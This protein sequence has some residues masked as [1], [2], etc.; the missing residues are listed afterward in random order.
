MEMMTITCDI[1]YDALVS[2]EYLQSVNPPPPFNFLFVLF[3]ICFCFVFCF[4]LG[5]VRYPC[6]S[7]TAS[8]MSIILQQCQIS[9]LPTFS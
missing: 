6:L 1:S 4:V 2:D 7:N 3:L 8:A 9:L 5:Y